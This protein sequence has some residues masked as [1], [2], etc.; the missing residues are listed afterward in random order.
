MGIPL[1]KIANKLTKI[2]AMFKIPHIFY[3]G[4]A[5]QRNGYA[6][7]TIDLNVVVPDIEYARDKLSMNGFKEVR[8]T[9]MQ[10]VDRE[11]PDY[12]IDLLPGG[13][14]VGPSLLNYPVPKKVSPTPIIA[15]IEDLISMKLATFLKKKQN[16][17]KILLMLSI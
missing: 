3:G 4:Y 11:N 14:S 6:R 1:D 5:V 2:L 9:T 10:L 17:F 13:K 15:N 7:T 12:I 8:G 16:E